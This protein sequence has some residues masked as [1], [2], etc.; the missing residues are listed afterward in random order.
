MADDD[1][2]GAA[3]PLD[4]V[5]LATLRAFC[6]D[7][8]TRSFTHTADGGDAPAAAS[9]RRRSRRDDEPDVPC[10]GVAAATLPTR[11][12]SPLRF[13]QLTTAQV[14]ELV[15]KPDTL[16]AGGCTYA[17]LLRARHAAAAEPLPSCETQP[18]VGRATVFVS[19]AW[20]YR[21]VDLADALATHFAAE[22]GAEAGAYLW[23]DVFVG[24]QHKAPTLPSAW[25]TQT[26]RGAVCAVGRTV[27]VLQP[28][29]APEPLTRS[30]CLVRP[31]THRRA[32]VRRAQAH[33]CNIFPALLTRM[34][35]VSLP[36]RAQWEIFCTVEGGVPLQI[37]LSSA[38]AAAFQHALEHRFEDIASALARIDTRNARAYKES[39]RAM[40][41][42]AVNASAGGFKAVNSCT[43]ACAT[44][45]RSRR[46]RCWRRAW[47]RT[48]GMTRLRCGWR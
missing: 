24:S 39:D 45:W 22:G 27:L 43:A 14:V 1:A 25:W 4:G 35:H 38:E 17:E 10:S 5:S 16:A 42:L 21:F 31:P 7:C 33:R 47:P 26:F 29:S 46:G 9:L 20:S 11:T 12:A 36:R 8:A 30:W 13:E 37:A 44:G 2:G 48:A 23:L 3:V 32:P 34:R 6:A 41:E 18:P 28:W 15:I 40:I 19:H